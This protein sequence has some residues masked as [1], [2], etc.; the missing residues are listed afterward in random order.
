MFI[1]ISLSNLAINKICH[2]FVI[3]FQKSKLHNWP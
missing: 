2:D 3:Y 1:E